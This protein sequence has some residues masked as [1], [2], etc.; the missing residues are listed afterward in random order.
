MLTIL[1]I[2]NVQ[3]RIKLYNILAKTKTYSFTY[4]DKTKVH[5]IINH[6]KCN[7]CKYIFNKTTNKQYFSLLR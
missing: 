6:Y 4:L 7:N 2:P 5:C 1:H 3:N